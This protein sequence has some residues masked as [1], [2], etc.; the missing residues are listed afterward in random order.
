MNYNYQ[1]V[2]LYFMKFI[3]CFHYK[4]IHLIEYLSLWCHLY[5]YLIL[6]QLWCHLYPILLYGTYDITMRNQII[7]FFAAFFQNLP[8]F[9]LNDSNSTLTCDLGIGMQILQHWKKNVW[10]LVEKVEMTNVN[11]CKNIIL[12][13][14]TEGIFTE[15]NFCWYNVVSIAIKHFQ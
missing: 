6:I 8:A 4:S 12:N 1:S 15:V 9:F 3:L 2:N 11:G 10:S 13:E 5:F 7:I 14:N